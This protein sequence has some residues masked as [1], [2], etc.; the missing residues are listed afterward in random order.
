MMA[1]DLQVVAHEPVLET[2]DAARELVQRAPISHFNVQLHIISV[3]VMI[4]T[5][6]AD[7]ATDRRD[8]GREEQRPELPCGTPAV[9][10]C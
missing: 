1:S 9:Y 8:V 4:D 10:G 6:S 2:A 7:N 3:C 5:K